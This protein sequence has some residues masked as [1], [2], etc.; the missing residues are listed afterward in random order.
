MAGGGASRLP[1]SLL[2][3]SIGGARGPKQSNRKVPVI[4]LKDTPN[5][6]FR[7]E[8]VAV[9]PGYARNFLIPQQLV[10]YSTLEIQAQFLKEKDEAEVL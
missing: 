2:A 7:G 10:V 3:W 4:L 1:T 8:E 9:R 5:L 6:G